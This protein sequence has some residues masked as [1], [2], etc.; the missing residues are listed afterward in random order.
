MIHFKI[1]KNGAEIRSEDGKLLNIYQKRDY[2]NLESMRSNV[3]ADWSKMVDNLMTL[4]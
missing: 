1:S 3:L 4:N 2:K